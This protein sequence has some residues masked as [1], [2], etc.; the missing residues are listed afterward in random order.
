VSSFFS[1]VLTTERPGKNGPLR[2]AYENGGKILYLGRISL[3]DGS[4]RQQ[5][6]ACYSQGNSA[7]GSD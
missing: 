7:I 3:V 2:F 6:L 4:L 1:V 5:V